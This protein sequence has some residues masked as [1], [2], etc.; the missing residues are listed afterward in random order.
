MVAGKPVPGPAEAGLNLVGD[1]DDAVLAAVVRQE[2]EKAGAGNDEPALPLDR[3]DQDSRDVARSHLGVDCAQ[4]LGGRLLAAALR[5]GGPAERIGHRHPVD[6]A[7]ERAE[8]VFVRHVLRRQRHGQVGTAMVSVIKGDHRLPPGARTCDLDRVLDGF[9]PRVE[10]RRPLGEGTRGE[11]GELLADRDVGLVR[12]EHEAGVRV[13]RHVLLHSGD[14]VRGGVADA[15]YSDAGPEVDEGVAVKVDDHSAAGAVDEDGQGGADAAGDGGVPPRLQLQRPRSRHAGH[16][17]AFLRQR[18]S[19]Q[20]TLH[21][22]VRAPFSSPARRTWAQFTRARLPVCCRSVAGATR[23][24]AGCT[25]R[26]L[27]SA[28]RLTSG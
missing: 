26:R 13:P 15:D 3:F 2:Q 22:H 5:S 17:P 21:R 6:L 19:T 10:Q 1:E 12:R 7:G 23:W 25:L 28:E 8:G 11:R 4:D 18:R 16:E 27:T 20:F 9:G 24:A 14:D